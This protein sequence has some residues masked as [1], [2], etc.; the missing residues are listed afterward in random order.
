MFLTAYIARRILARV[1]N[2]DGGTRNWGARTV[3]GS[4]CAAASTSGSRNV[5]MSMSPSMY[6]FAD[7]SVIEMISEIREL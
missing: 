3:M 6:G 7:R 1:L 5:G 4:I 2:V